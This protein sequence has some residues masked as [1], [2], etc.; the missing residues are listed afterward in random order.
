MKAD[1]HFD[2]KNFKSCYLKIHSYLKISV[3]LFI[4]ECFHGK[5]VNFY[6]SLFPHVGTDYA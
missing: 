4:L 2:F 3:S 6:I 5:P 1:T